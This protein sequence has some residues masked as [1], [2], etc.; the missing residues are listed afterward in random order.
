M[1][2]NLIIIGLIILAGVQL[3]F[4][5]SEPK[6]PDSHANDYT[7]VQ[8]DNKQLKAHRDSGLKII[9]S[10]QF[11]ISQRE[12][13]V[14]QLEEQ[15]AGYRIDLDKSSAKAVQ[16]ANDIK[17]LQRPDTSIA[18]RKCDSLAIEAE[19]FAY[20]YNAYKRY[21][22][23]LTATTNKSIIDYQ[24]AMNEQKK[25][26]DELQAKYDQ[27]Y[28]LYDNLYK[29]YNTGQKSLRR[30]RLKTKI[31]ALLALIGG[32]AAVIK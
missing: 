9:D 4:L 24:A 16:L 7:M 23:T 2:K 19:N 21:V 11:V 3:Y 10:L 26:Y 13:V 18:D 8:E 22:D 6:Q 17:T 12:L 15:L 14:S 32:A 28:R 27:L 1:K 29:D 20:L 25:L 31:A 30:E 5:L